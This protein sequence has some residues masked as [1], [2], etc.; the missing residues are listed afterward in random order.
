MRI[1]QARETKGQSR[2]NPQQLFLVSKWRIIHLS[3]ENQ[4]LV[5]AATRLLE[6]E[7]R[8]GMNRRALSKNQ[9]IGKDY[10]YLPFFRTCPL[11]FERVKHKM[12]LGSGGLS[13][14]RSRGLWLS[15]CRTE[16]PSL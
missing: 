16:S 6:L 3:F 15:F 7:H 4:H 8:M 11:A 5:M 12:F 9:Y 10:S 13:I 1:S 2:E 14:S